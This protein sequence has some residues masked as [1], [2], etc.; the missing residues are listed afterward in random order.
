[1]VMWVLLSQKYLKVSHKKQ[2]YDPYNVRLETS[3]MD[4]E[5]HPCEIFEG[6]WNP[7]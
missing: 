6:I 2:F 7:E 4:I 3:L 1:M 5:F